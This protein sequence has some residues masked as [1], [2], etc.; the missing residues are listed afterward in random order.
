MRHN[1]LFLCGDAKLIERLETALADDGAVM[2]LDPRTG[3]SDDL[4][5]RFK[6]D[7]VVIDAGAHSGAKTMLERMTAVRARFPALPLI[8]IGDEM[9]AQ[10]ILTA[11]RAGVDDFVDRDASDAEIRNMILSRI[12]EKSTG[13]TGGAPV[14][15]VNILSP[16]P[17]DEDADLALNIASLMA[18]AGRR[19]LLLDLSL[20]VTPIRASLGLEAGFTVM[21][22]LRDVARL[23][24]T[25]LDAALA[26]A[27]DT[28]LYLLPLADEDTDAVLPA[29]R[30]L[31]VLLQVL[32]T[33]FDSVV[34]HW[35]AFSRPALR[36]G[37]VQGAVFLGCNQRFA[38][39][40]NAKSFLAHLHTA[41]LGIE[42]VLVI[43]QLDANLVPSPGEIIAA[44]G[45]RH[46]FTLRANWSALA[47]A[48]NRGRPLGLAGPSSYSDALRTHLAGTGL[49]PQAPAEPVTVK[50][51]HW[52]NR[53][54]TG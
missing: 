46:S 13:G 9:S 15:Q 39:I 12:R 32:G 27:P 10:L 42:P 5:A 38:S 16:A 40:R 30:D 25:F 52:L 45:A 51:L 37:T 35:G 53:A 1:L 34:I 19:A 24:R 26:R 7:A 48:H 49:L 54:R 44:T 3:G 28:G 14:A 21:A 2:A 47:L 17:S 50:L 41:Q 29:P 20:P 18:A 33:L 22:A 4:A 6:P 31:A 8:A 11:F 23:D 36:A 43:H